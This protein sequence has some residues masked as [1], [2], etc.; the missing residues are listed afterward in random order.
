MTEAC[1]LPWAR[2]YFR[3]SA[4]GLKFNTACQATDGLSITRVNQREEFPA[5]Q[6]ISWIE[7]AGHGT[8]PT[9]P[10]RAQ[11]LL[12]QPEHHRGLS[13]H[14][15]ACRRHSHGIL[16]WKWPSTLVDLLDHAGPSSAPNDEQVLLLW[17]AMTGF[18]VDD[19]RP[20]CTIFSTA[21]RSR[22]GRR[23]DYGRPPSS[24]P[25]GPMQI[26]INLFRSQSAR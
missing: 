21:L 26:Q 11:P 18:D 2:A 9:S 15:T 13:L 10:R 20:A 4:K 14:N 23:Q 12:G 19:V 25:K 17:I 1:R 5:V 7:K 8:K 6:D 22:N 3:R 16:T 24:N